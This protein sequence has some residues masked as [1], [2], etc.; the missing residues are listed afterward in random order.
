MEEQFCLVQHDWIIYEKGFTLTTDL[1]E[2]MIQELM[3][4]SIISC[5]RLQEHYAWGA[6]YPVIH[7]EFI[8]YWYL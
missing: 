4:S 2:K 3:Y 1:F 6:V 5:L 7:K 8:Q